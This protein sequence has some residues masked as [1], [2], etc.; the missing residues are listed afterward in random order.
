MKMNNLQQEKNRSHLQALFD[1]NWTW[2]AKQSEFYVDI[3][4]HLG[5]GYATDN[6]CLV[7]RKS[8]V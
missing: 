2:N 4:S 6:S 7:D 5:K 1:A 3:Y 8:V